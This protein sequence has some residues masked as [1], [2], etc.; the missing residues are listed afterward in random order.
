MVAVVKHEVF[1]SSTFADLIEARRKVISAVLQS[2]CF[3]SSME[4]FPAT[5][6]EQVEFIHHMIDEADFY[7]L[8]VGGAYG[9]MHSSGVSFTEREFDYTVSKGKPILAY[10]HKDPAALPP[11]RRETDPERQSRFDAFCEKVKADR[12]VGFWTSEDDL[13]AQ[14][15]LGLAR[16]RQITPGGGWVRSDQAVGA[17]TVRR[18][19]EISKEL[20]EVKEDR[21]LAARALARV[22]ELD[23]GLFDTTIEVHGYSAY[24][25]ID[26]QVGEVAF[27]GAGAAARDATGLQQ[28]I[29][30]ILAN[31]TGFA[32]VEEKSAATALST[33]VSLGLFREEAGSL[34]V[35]EAVLARVRLWKSGAAGAAR[36]EDAAAAVQAR[37]FWRRLFGRS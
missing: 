14:V 6:E 23:D 33:L 19:A 12:V 8:I 3:I 9:S 15:V 29:A 16:Q 20:D 11:D 36:R 35:D 27:L 5:S 24:E 1:L 28:H 31:M 37:P 13:A 2:G 10:L 30:Q 26:L 4:Y 17:E 21:D 22:I 18:I 7:L 32:E 34:K 25:R